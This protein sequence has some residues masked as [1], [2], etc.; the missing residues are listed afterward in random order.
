MNLLNTTVKALIGA[1][2]IIFSIGVSN[3]SIIS[4]SGD[5]TLISAPTSVGINALQSDSDLFGFSEVQ[6]FTLLSDTYVNGTGSG[7]FT[8]TGNPATE[9]ITA[10]TSVDSYLFHVD[11]VTA[12]PAT[13]FFGDVTFGTDILGIIFERSE[14][15]QTDLTL[16]FAGTFYPGIEAN[17]SFREFE[18]GTAGCGVGIFD[19]ATISGDLRTLILDM[20]TT[21][22]IDQIR[23][24]TAASVPEPASIA[25]MGFGLVGLGFARRK[26][27]A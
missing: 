9:M 5:V 6:N 4:T 16:G 26:K 12:T 17:S 19:C 8:G 25:L 3:A 22:Q 11:S 15:N 18:F 7:L 1:A 23:V 20:G 21:T 14:L 10:G 27:T 13:R 24:I 2:S